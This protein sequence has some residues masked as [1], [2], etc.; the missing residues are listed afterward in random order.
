MIKLSASQKNALDTILS[1]LGAGFAYLGSSSSSIS[2]HYA[3]LISLGGLA[4]GYFV[5]DAISI[6][7]NGVV[8]VSTIESQAKSTW[9]ASGKAELT[10][11]VQKL[12]PAAH[13]PVAQAAIA[14]I[15]AEMQKLGA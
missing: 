3:P 13:L 2:S 4:G 7:E 6:V 15:D 10:S 12:V 8:A 5:S 11:V 14:A 1:L 9:N